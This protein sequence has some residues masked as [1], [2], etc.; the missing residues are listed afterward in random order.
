LYAEFDPAGRNEIADV[1]VQPYKLPSY[2][3]LDWYI[4]SDFNI[5]GVKAYAG[6]N[7]NNILDTEY[8]SEGLDGPSHT[9]DDVA[10]WWG[11]Q[12]TFTFTTKIYF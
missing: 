2:G 7:V 10:G 5:G 3:L 8:M 4:G 11:F 6:M 9:Y 1:G 12:R